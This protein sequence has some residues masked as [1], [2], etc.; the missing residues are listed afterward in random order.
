MNI[1]VVG[2]G[3]LGIAFATLL[4]KSGHRVCGLTKA[5]YL[6][7]FGD[8]KVRLSGIWGEHGAVLDGVYSD[9]Q[10]LMH[11]KP[12]LIIL[13]VKSF[14][15]EET[16]QAIAPLV[17]ERTLVM[18][19]QNGYG[20]YET[21]A[22]IVGKE[23]ALLAR[24]IFGAKLL[25]VGSSEVTGIA[26]AVRLGQPDGAVP[27]AICVK[28][29]QAINAAGIPTAHAPDVYGILWDKILYNCAL[30]PLGALL[31]CNYGSLADDA[32]V[33][34]VMNAMIK[35]IFDVAKAHGI[36]LRWRSAG[37]YIH[38][39]YEKLLPPTRQHFPSTYH[40]LKA[41]KKLEID[42]LTGAIVRLGKENGV[43]TPVNETVTN[44]IKAKERFLLRSMAS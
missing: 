23:H 17:E 30:N 42:A 21:L 13:T 43:P 32:G 44:L 22:R 20:N 3:A 9:I 11:N 6:S 29:A 24:V 28:I 7:S 4:K 40:D 26:D 27:E 37:D 10:P 1:L 2:L 12:D 34:Q 19:A 16:V 36:T 15:T 25:G 5:K 38:Y 41:G 33:R 8:K 18:A 35:E 31:E 14:D 39:F